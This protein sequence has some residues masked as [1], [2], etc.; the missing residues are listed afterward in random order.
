[1]SAFIVSDNHIHAIVNYIMQRRTFGSM[2]VYGRII[3][4]KDRVW[5]EIETDKQATMLGQFFLDANYESVNYRYSES[6]A[7]HKYKFKL[8]AAKVST[9]QFLK[10]LNCLDYQCCEP[11]DYRNGDC[12]KLI[13]ELQS[14]AASHLAGYDE[15]EWE[16]K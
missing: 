12:Y 1:M 15:A 16:I 11:N 4:V 8:Q 5:A 7:P 3:G 6:D 10:A 2:N 14:S 13:R 9:V